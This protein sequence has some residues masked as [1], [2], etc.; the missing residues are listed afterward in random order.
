MR[1]GW[2]V[3]FLEHVSRSQIDVIIYNYEKTTLGGVGE[4]SLSKSEVN[5]KGKIIA[6]V[7]LYLVSNL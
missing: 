5:L 4:Q 7:T 3:L 6:K 2:T 1:V